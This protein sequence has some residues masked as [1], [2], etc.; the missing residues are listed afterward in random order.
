[1]TTCFLLYNRDA[2]AIGYSVKKLKALLSW[3]SGKDSA[4]ALYEILRSQEFEV[5]GLLTTVTDDFERVSMHGVRETLLERQAESL[6]LPLYK[7][8]IP[9]PCPNEVYEKKMFDFL[10]GWKE[11]GVRHV[12]FGDLFLED[13][14]AYRVNNLAKLKMEGIFPLWLRN[15][16][17]LAEEMIAAGF[18]AHIVCVDPKKL[19]KNFSGRV[20]DEKL[21]ADLP[22]ACDPC[23]ENGEFHTFVHAGPIFKKEIAVQTGETVE[24]EGFVFTDLCAI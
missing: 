3:S 21:L 5:V 16:K 23:G 1:M 24:R 7:I 22:P 18:K 13:V 8:R 14:R 2:C 10:T 9:Y 12:I 19:P 15:T 17:K 11:K 6:G 20:F 4:F